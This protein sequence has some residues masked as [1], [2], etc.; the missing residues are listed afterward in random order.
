MF[1]SAG[2]NDN[3]IRLWS[4]DLDEVMSRG[5]DWARDYLTNNPNVSKEDRKICDGIGSK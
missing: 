4:L 3:T 5:C 2:A 1:A